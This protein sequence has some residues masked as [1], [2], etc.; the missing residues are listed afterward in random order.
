MLIS[1][2]HRMLNNQILF[3]LYFAQASDDEVDKTVSSAYQTR[4]SPDTQ[5]VT[6]TPGAGVAEDHRL[7]NHSVIPSF[8]QKIV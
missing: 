4:W 2:Y 8:P 5:R 3:Y 1:D 6:V 7:G